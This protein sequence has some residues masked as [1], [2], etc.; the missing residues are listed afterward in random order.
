MMIR[1]ARET[2]GHVHIVHLADAECLPMIAEARAEGLKLTVETCPHYLFFDAESIPDRQ[3]QFKCAPPIRDT[4]NRE[5]L[6]GGLRDGLI[7]M[8]VSDHSPCPIELKELQ[9]GRFDL[10]WGGVSSLQLGLPVIWTAAQQRGFSLS[11]VVRWM[12]EAPAKA[13]WV[14]HKVLLLVI[15]RTW[16]SSIQTRHGKSTRSHCFTRTLSRPT[17]ETN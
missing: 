12:S 16:S 2:G 9:S 17:T 1:L 13:G 3:T 14:C 7:D 6:W 10:A 8:I 11:D 15:Q 5:G 4:D